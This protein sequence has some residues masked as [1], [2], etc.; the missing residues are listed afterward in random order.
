VAADGRVER[1]RLDPA[2]LGIAVVPADALRGGDPAFNAAV[3]RDV[4]AGKDRG[5]VR[6]VVLLN[7]AAAI[8][9]YDGCAA[10]SLP[11]EIER[12]MRVAAEAI[13]S[14]AAADVLQRWVAACR[15]LHPAR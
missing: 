14:G 4:L 8:A 11:A 5:G 7:A 3:A 1:V 2:A 13:D 15:R 9:A 10:A 6:D 12:G